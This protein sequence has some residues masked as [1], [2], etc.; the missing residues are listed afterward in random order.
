M[1]TPIVCKHVV[2]SANTTESEKELLVEFALEAYQAVIYYKK[3]YTVTANRRGRLIVN[4]FN[5]GHR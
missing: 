2:R 3:G 5:A 1:V 4:E